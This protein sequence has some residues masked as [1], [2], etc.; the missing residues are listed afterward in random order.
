MNKQNKRRK[1]IPQ[2]GGTA[3]RW[4]S[5]MNLLTIK[6]NAPSV[7][8]FSLSKSLKKSFLYPSIAFYTLSRW[9]SIVTPFR[10]YCG[11]LSDNERIVRFSRWMGSIVP[12]FLLAILQLIFCLLEV[13]WF[14]FN[15]VSHTSSILKKTAITSL[16][17]SNTCSAYQTCI[18]MHVRSLQAY[19][20]L[21]EA[22]PKMIQRCYRTKD[23]WTMEF[24][25]PQTKSKC[26]P[27]N[28]WSN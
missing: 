9:S 6:T 3:S 7:S 5:A 8:R 14:Y 11:T 28:D 17:L 26:I 20:L 12:G 15:L 10:N 22:A 1:K 25:E 18:K 27:M 4:L 2:L 19:T 21:S 24:C 13:F 16:I 23:C